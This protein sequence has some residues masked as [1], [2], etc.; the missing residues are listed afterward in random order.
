[1]IGPTLAAT[2]AI[3]MSM[4]RIICILIEVKM[5]TRI[6]FRTSRSSAIEA[7]DRRAMPT[8]AHRIG[9]ST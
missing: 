5:G 9:D 2:G 6:L 8:A 4:V 1:M 7:V 3:A